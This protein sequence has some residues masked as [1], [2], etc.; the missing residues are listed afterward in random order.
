MASRAAQTAS[1]RKNALLSGLGL[2]LLLMAT[3]LAGASLFIVL[4]DP[5]EIWWEIADYDELKHTTLFR[6]GW[7]PD[8]VPK[9][10]RDLKGWNNIDSG[11][12]EV[13]FYIDTEDMQSLI[14][15]YDELTPEGFPAK[16]HTADAGGNG[17]F[18]CFKARSSVPGSQYVYFIAIEMNTGWVEYRGYTQY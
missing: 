13:E 10:V 18:R 16:F 2:C 5:D 15:G 14:K 9:S 11:R 4:F 7:L 8:M 6:N 17:R 12:V 3:L 1:G